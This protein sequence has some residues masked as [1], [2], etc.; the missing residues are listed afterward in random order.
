MVMAPRGSKITW[1][2]LLAFPVENKLALWPSGG[3][4]IKSESGNSSGILGRGILNNAI[5]IRVSIRQ[6]TRSP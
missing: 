2:C 1:A 5:I 4:E 6:G 3:I